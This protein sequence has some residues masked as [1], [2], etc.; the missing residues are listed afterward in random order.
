MQLIDL[1]N[2]YKLN[3]SKIDPNIRI[4]GYAIV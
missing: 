3:C 1:Y 4:L 2:L